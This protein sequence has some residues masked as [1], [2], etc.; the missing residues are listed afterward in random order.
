MADA[1]A[2]R[3]DAEILERALA[4]FQEVVA[5]AVALVLERHV[6]RQRLGRAEL[7]DDDRMVNHQ[8][9]GHQRIDHRR[10]AAELG[11]AIA[12]SGKIDH[13]GHAGEVLHQH[14]GGSEPDVLVGLAAILEPGGDGL[15]VGLGDRPA[16]LVPQQ[17]LEQDLQRKRQLGDAGKA[18]LFGFDE[19]V[20]AV[21]LGPDLQR[22]FALEAVKGGRRSRD[23]LDGHGSGSRF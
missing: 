6:L 13:G 20:I 21:S 11:H 5:L 2:G 9:D 7:V 15:D 18:V 14:A 3:H 16:V 22:A 12:H 23:G 10:I 19:R 17:V 8:I 1:C 4:P